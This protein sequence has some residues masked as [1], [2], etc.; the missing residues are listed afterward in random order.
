[1]QH[2]YHGRNVQAAA[3]NAKPKLPSKVMMARVIMVGS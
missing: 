3:S 2:G 1:V